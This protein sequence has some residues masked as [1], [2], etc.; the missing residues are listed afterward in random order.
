MGCGL[1][2]ARKEPKKTVVTEAPAAAKHD[3]PVEYKTAKD[4]APP[5]PHVTPAAAV[6]HREKGPVEADAALEL[7]KQG[8][9]RYRKGGLRKDG[10]TIKD[11]ERL[12]K[13][14]KPHTIVFS[15]SDS[16]VPPELVFDQKLGELFVVR[17]AG[18][19]AD[20]SAI[21]SIEYAIEHLGANLI[22]V[23]GHESC[24]AVRAAH[25]AFAGGDAGSPHITALVKDIQPRI[26]L[27]ASTPIS[28]GAMDE[29]WANV[30]GTAKDLMEKSDIIRHAVATGEVKI[31]RSIYHLSTGQVEWK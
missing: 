21:A 8:N 4:A 28:Q 30:I 1:S 16:R 29:S 9:Q 18:Q 3:S 24:G 5:T 19:S 7:L 20:F 26:N 23:M 6:S 22:V 10:A 11:R 2:N 14:Q 27:F 12:S 17:T 15:C 31:A 25:G 13:G